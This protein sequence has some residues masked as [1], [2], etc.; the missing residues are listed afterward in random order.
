MFDSFLQT[1]KKHY[2]NS[3][4][5]SICLNDFNKLKSLY[6]WGSNIFYHLAALKNIHPTYIQT[7]L[8]DD[9]YTN[10]QI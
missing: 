10:K 3:E 6:G 4:E 1:I 2:G 8:S 7:L 5:L 9:R